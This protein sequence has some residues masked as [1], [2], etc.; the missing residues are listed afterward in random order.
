MQ[1]TEGHTRIWIITERT[2]KIFKISK[3]KMKEERKPD[4][5]TEG[6]KEGEKTQRTIENGEHNI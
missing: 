2:R 1:H 4:D 5:P 6:M 3:E